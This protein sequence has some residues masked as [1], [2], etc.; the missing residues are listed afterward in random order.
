MN[1]YPKQLCLGFIV[2]SLGFVYLGREHTFERIFQFIFS[3]KASSSFR[4]QPE[5]AGKNSFSKSEEES[6]RHHR[7]RE[8]ETDDVGRRSGKKGRRRVC[9]CV[10]VKGVAF[11]LFT[12][13]VLK[14]I[15]IGDLSFETVQRHWSSWASIPRSSKRRSTRC[16]GKCSDLPPREDRFWWI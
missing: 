12:R 2:Y 6:F 9:V 15:Y 10:C 7:P 4:F 13:F 14:S 16:V 8:E 11:L 1:A 3:Q 5:E